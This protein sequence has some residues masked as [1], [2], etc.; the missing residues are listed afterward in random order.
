MLSALRL[1][2]V[3]LAASVAACASAPE[4]APSG[5]PSGGAQ[6]APG[7]PEPGAAATGAT[8]SPGPVSSVPPPPQLDPSPGYSEALRV[9]ADGIAAEVAVPP[10]SADASSAEVA[11]FVEAREAGI[12]RTF[13]R[14]V[15]RVEPAHPNREGETVLS[16]AFAGWAYEHVA[17]SIPESEGAA[18][19]RAEWLERA[20]RAYADCVS[21]GAMLRAPWQRAVAYC[22]ARLQSL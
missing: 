15:E 18:P 5:A 4:S 3:S 12:A 21:A 20:R 9:V 17:R 6:T 8:T 22:E 19:M 7:A 1:A 13:D 10:P 14:S 11:A 2:L 16:A